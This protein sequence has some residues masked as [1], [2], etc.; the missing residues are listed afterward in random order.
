M[1]FL[2]WRGVVRGSPFAEKPLQASF[3][4]C[5]VEYL[6]HACLAFPQFLRVLSSI[7]QRAGRNNK[8][9]NIIQR[10]IVV[11]PGNDR[12][13]DCHRLRQPLGQRLQKNIAGAPR[14]VCGILAIENTFGTKLNCS[15]TARG[16]AAG[17]AVRQNFS[18]WM[19]AR[20]FTIPFVR[21]RKEQAWT[22]GC[23]DYSSSRDVKEYK[24]SVSSVF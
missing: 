17:D 16:K 14:Y 19:P 11:F 18:P 21:L 10:N 6:P 2:F 3:P 5:I 20:F 7:R 8:H 9:R 15:F 12:Q 1:F 24:F 22:L 23:R 13:G 4:A